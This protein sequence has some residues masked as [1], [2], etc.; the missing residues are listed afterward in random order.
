MNSIHFISFISF[1]LFI[2]F[3]LFLFK[4]SLDLICSRP[5]QY[6]PYKPKT[7]FSIAFRCK[8]VAAIT[9][10]IPNF[11]FFIQ[12]PIFG[13]NMYCLI[14]EDTVMACRMCF[15]RSNT[16]SSRELFSKKWRE[17]NAVLDQP[18]DSLMRIGTKIN[19]SLFHW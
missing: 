7:F 13:R 16:S 11:V 6:T 8:N 9:K 4:S 10:N 14:Q 19:V 17:G 18:W 15:L 12:N 1:I 5:V 2:H 3:M